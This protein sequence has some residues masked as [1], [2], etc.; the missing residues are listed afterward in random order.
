M[1][2]ESKK[3]RHELKKLKIQ[4][5]YKQLNWT[6]IITVALVAVIVSALTF[7][8]LATWFAN[9][10]TI[11][12]GQVVSR[13]TVALGENPELM[14]GFD[15]DLP[16][17]ALYLML[18]KQISAEIGADASLNFQSYFTTDV[19]RTLEKVDLECVDKY[20]YLKAFKPGKAK[21]GTS[22]Y[23]MRVGRVELLKDEGCTQYHA[24]ADTL[25]LKCPQRNCELRE[26]QVEVSG[27]FIPTK[28]GVTRLSVTGLTG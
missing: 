4:H 14:F 23:S 6:L 25:Y 21:V 15:N 27:E 22:E 16:E 8:A 7:A 24:A 28:L 11:A 19:R 2:E 10:F 13:G 18:A 1:S 5:N 12:V 3:K 17:E 26:K 9:A 20:H